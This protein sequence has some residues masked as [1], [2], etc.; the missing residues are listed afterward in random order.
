MIGKFAKVLFQRISFDY[1]FN[2]H[3]I[4]KM[5]NDTWVNSCY[6]HLIVDAINKYIDL[7]LPGR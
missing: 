7:K 4:L 5:Y 1:N 2:G 3:A 6:Y